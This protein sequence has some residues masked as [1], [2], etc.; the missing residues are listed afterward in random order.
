MSDNPRQKSQAIPIFKKPAGDVMLWQAADG[1]LYVMNGLLNGNYAWDAAFRAEYGEN[2]GRKIAGTFTKESLNFLFSIIKTGTGESAAV[3]AGLTTV[4]ILAKGISTSLGDAI[5]GKKLSGSD[6]AYNIY[7]E[8]FK[9]SNLAPGAKVAG[10]GTLAT[11]QNMAY[12]YKNFITTADPSFSKKK[13]LKIDLPTGEK[14]YLI[15]GDIG[16]FSI[17]KRAEKATVT[18]IKHKLGHKPGH[19]EHAEGNILE[20]YDISK[21]AKDW[22]VVDAENFDR[23]IKGG[24]TV[25]EAVILVSKRNRSDIG[26]KIQNLKGEVAQTKGIFEAGSESVFVSMNMQWDAAKNYWN[27][28]A[29][30][31]ADQMIQGDFSGLANLG[32]SL[33]HG[34]AAGVDAVVGSVSWVVGKGEAGSREMIGSGLNIATITND[35]GRAVSGTGY[36]KVINTPIT[37]TGPVT[38]QP[39]LQT[40]YNTSTPTFRGINSVQVETNKKQDEKK[41]TATGRQAVVEKSKSYKQKAE[42]PYKYIRA[43]TNTR[44][45]IMTSGVMGLF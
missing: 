36:S 6:V 11:V 35:I 42:D 24:F 9:I 8:L 4:K 14:D 43:N 2:Y 44:G 45:P 3:A 37:A 13:L 15:K 7:S 27:E 12:K 22:D 33:F 17:G 39:V 23:F 21:Y 34:L 28:S 41:P 1:S 29:K 40:G 26:A 38:L 31:R 32:L 5:E 30:W 19:G 10:T 25:D 18:Y 20:E 16:F